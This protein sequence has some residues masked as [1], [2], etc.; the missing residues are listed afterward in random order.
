[1]TIALF[2]VSSLLVSAEAATPPT[3][4]LETVVNATAEEAWTLWTTN[5]GVQSFFPGARNGGTNIRLAPDGPYEFFFIPENPP[6]MRGC[7]GC[8]ILGFQKG[9]MLSFTWTNRPDHAVRPHR[10][11]VTLRFQ[12]LSATATRVTL[13]HDGWGEGEDWRVPYDYFAAAWPR[14]LE[15]YRRGFADS[16]P[17]P[18]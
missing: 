17:T 5:E 12:P 4:E 6:G 9:K 8:V 15:A 16:E 3:I 14:V 10:T 2:V 13:E 11:H 7:D 1:M 18:P